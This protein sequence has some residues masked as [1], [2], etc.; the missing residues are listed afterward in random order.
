MQVIN[1]LACPVKV[2]IEN[3]TFSVS[4]RQHSLEKRLSVA[5]NISI[6][7]TPN[8]CHNLSK[9][10][11]AITLE[12]NQWYNF[13]ISYYRGAIVGRVIKENI[14]LPPPG[15]AKLCAL[16]MP[17]AVDENFFEIFLEK[18]KVLSNVSGT[19]AS[20]CAVASANRYKLAVKG[21]RSGK[22]YV[23]S[24]VSLKNGGVYT[25]VVH[26]SMERNGT[27]EVGVYEDLEA[28]SISMFWQIPQYFVIT[29]GEIL[30]SIT[31]EL[32]SVEITVVVLC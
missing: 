9:R 21:S 22:L 31:G 17:L 20:S 7:I 24:D 29:S 25:A 1:S 23:A 28:K 14:T 27:V 13:V 16:V 32:C 18:N 2:S 8:N 30:F 11:F 26:C 4:S 19:E 10:S 5:E 3:K 15:K 12:E 6:I